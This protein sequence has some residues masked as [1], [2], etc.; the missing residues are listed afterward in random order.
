MYRLS[1][2]T[3]SGM[4]N[5]FNIIEEP[6]FKDIDLFEGGTVYCD[7]NWETPQEIPAINKNVLVDYIL[8]GCGELQCWRQNPDRFKL[9]SER[10]F[11]A[12]YNNFRMMWIALNMN[13]N[14]IDN[15]D[16][17]EYI[18]DDY[19]SKHKRTDTTHYK[20]TNDVDI[21]GLERN[22]ETPS[23]SE[24]TTNKFDNHQITENTIS[25]DNSSGYQSDNK[26][27][28][29]MADTTTKLTYDQGRQ[30]VNE[31]QYFDR[32][33]NGTFEHIYLDG[34][35]LNEHLGDDTRKIWAHG[36][37]GVK[38]TSEIIQNELK[39]RQFNFYNYVAR[40]YE[41]E[42]MMEVY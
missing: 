33:N 4:Y 31:L 23:G 41:K 6:L 25:A 42:L 10:F 27:D 16:R 11:T 28:V 21:L 24:T 35:D 40:L 37:I 7:E 15:Y 30:T 34:N 14:P 36:N 38:E 17:H 1:G 5:Y 2:F 3:L 8:E 19:H 22:T 18:L 26:S 9:M 39:L 12:N 13:Y 29:T 20:D 32:A